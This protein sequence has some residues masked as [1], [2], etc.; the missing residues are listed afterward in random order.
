MSSIRIVL[1]YNGAERLWNVWAESEQNIDFRRNRFAAERCT[2]C[3]AAFELKTF[4]NKMDHK[5]IVNISENRPI[6]G[7]FIELQIESNDSSGGFKLTPSGAGVI[8]T[9]HDRS[10]LLNGAY[11]LLRMQGWRWIEPGDKGEFNPK[12]STLKWP[13]KEIEITPSF[14]YRGIDAYRESQD[15][16]EYM[17]W[18]SRNRMNVCFRKAVTGKLADKLGMYSRTGGHLLQKIA[19]PDRYLETGKTIWEEHPEWYGLPVDGVRSKKLVTRTQLCVSQSGLLRFIGEELLKMLNSSLS[20]IDIVDIWGFDTWGAICTCPSCQ[21]LGNGADHNLLLLSALRKTLDKARKDGRL[22]RNVLMDISSYE[23][24]VSLEAPTKPLPKNIQNSGDICIFYPIKRCYQHN[25]EDDTCEINRK[26]SNAWRQWNKNAKGM[27]IWSGEYYNVSKYE[28]LPLVFSKKIPNDMRF[29]H[30]TGGNGTT[31]MHAIFINWAMRSLT[32]M[33]HSQYSWDINTN[34]DDFLKDYFQSRYGKYAFKMQK[35]YALIEKAGSDISAWRN[36]AVGALDILRAWDGCIPSKSLK[37]GHFQNIYEA[38]KAAERS[39][40]YYRRAID[41][42][43][44]CLE[45]EQAQNWKTLPLPN[46]VPVNPQELACFTSFDYMEQLLG[47]SLRLLKYGTD[48]M[49]LLVCIL[50]YHNA[51]F[52][53]NWLEADKYWED[54]EIIAKEMNIYFQPISFEKPSVGLI[55]QDAL[56]RSQYRPVIARCRGARISGLVPVGTKRRKL[57]SV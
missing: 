22:D 14:K 24:T 6:N 17:L 28:D 48:T 9:G 16:V 45:Q 55:S 33:Q 53:K 15:S 49:S 12:C 36:W 19:C 57:P 27:S 21:K 42:V 13:E 5:L 54:V 34:D 51:L 31:Y 26:Y 32:Q 50:N 7:N 29:Y 10:G 3:F 35:A 43:D 39:V 2:A 38:I 4:I 23:G 20:N 37:F 8:V 46:Y 25:I 41:I 18:M 44:K 47:E 30:A 56:T 11:E 52:N 40:K 1:P